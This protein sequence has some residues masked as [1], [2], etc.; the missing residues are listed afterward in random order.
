MLIDGIWLEI[1]LCSVITCYSVTSF[2]EYLWLH[3]NVYLGIVKIKQ[4]AE[5]PTVRI[6]IFPGKSL[7]CPLYGNW[8]ELYGYLKIV[9]WLLKSTLTV[10]HIH[11]TCTHMRSTWT[12][13]LHVLC[14][15]FN[16]TQKRCKIRK[17][18]ARIRKTQTGGWQ[19]WKRKLLHTH[20]QHIHHANTFTLL[21]NH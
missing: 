8:W 7:P 4:R 13:K 20:T 14:W 16:G 6:N 11:R 1:W 18:I 12:S 2:W 21:L 9:K 15:K 10:L 17:N 5:L 3:C 19:L